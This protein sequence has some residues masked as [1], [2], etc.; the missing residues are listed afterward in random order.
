MPHRLRELRLQL[1]W[2]AEEL[3][4]RAGSFQSTISRIEAG[5]QQLSLEWMHRLALA[6]GVRAADLIAGDDAVK[7]A[8][9]VADLRQQDRRDPM[10]TDAESYLLP[11]PMRWP[12]SAVD[13]APIAFQVAENSWLFGEERFPMPEYVGKRFVVRFNVADHSR[14]KL[15]LY[16]FERLSGM[17]GFSTPEGSPDDRWLRV[18]CGRIKQSWLVRAE[19]REL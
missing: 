14:T 15:A 4:R 12:E 1:G 3:A 7:F 9:V 5:Q 2:S 16:T 18:G 6:L 10:F 17:A 8:K 19:F 13:N 11:I